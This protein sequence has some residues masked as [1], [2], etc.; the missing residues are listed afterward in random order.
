MVNFKR[1]HKNWCRTCTPFEKGLRRYFH[2]EE[3]EKVS[4]D[5]EHILHL[6]RSWEGIS[7]WEGWIFSNILI[8]EGIEKVFFLRRTWEAWNYYRVVEMDLRRWDGSE[9]EMYPPNFRALLLGWLSSARQ[10]LSQ[11][12]SHVTPYKFNSSHWL[13][14]QHSDWKANLVKDFFLQINFPPMRALKFITGHMIFKLSYNQ[15]YQLKT[16]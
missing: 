5:V 4:T 6:R 12:K 1:D 2:W 8:W 11:L 13:K 9:K 7:I 15:I 16:T 10:K 14:L 3:S